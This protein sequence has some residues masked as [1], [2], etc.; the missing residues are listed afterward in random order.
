MSRPRSEAARQAALDATV[1]LLLEV[2]VEGVTFEEVAAR[3]GVARTTLYR[4][5]GSK[6]AMIVEAASCC[7]VE[8]PTP[9]TGDLEDDL[10]AIMD[11]WKETEER[12][13][14]SDV[15]PA[16][17]TASERDEDLRALVLALLAERRRP[18]RTAL[19]LAQLRGD[20]A[21]DL[22][23]DVALALLTG[24]FVERRMLDRKDI[25]DDFRD[26]VLRHFV[27]GL[28]A[29]AGRAVSV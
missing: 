28:Q 22:D 17:L 20:I 29:A 3:S 4:H 10:R 19:Q 18:L 21:P 6:Q 9:D 26:A 15:I 7:L 16:L 12:N 8:L 5:F 25:D 27:A 23:L 13:R 1:D 11:R 24:P 2:G 14:V